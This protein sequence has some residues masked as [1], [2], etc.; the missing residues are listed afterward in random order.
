MN[1]LVMG[2][3][4]IGQMMAEDITGAILGGQ[5]QLTRNAMFAGSEK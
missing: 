2:S 3:R 4:I 1:V 5:V